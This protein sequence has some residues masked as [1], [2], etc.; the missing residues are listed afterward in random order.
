[1][2]HPKL[3]SV[4]RKVKAMLLSG[5]SRHAIASKLN[6][7]KSSVYDVVAN[8]EHYGEIRAIPG[9]KNPVIY[10][11]PNISGNPTNLPPKGEESGDSG[12]NGWAVRNNGTSGSWSEGLPEVNFTGI[13]IGPDCP[14]GYVVAHMSGGIR[15]TKV[16]KV[17]TFDPIKDVHGHTVGIWDPEKPTNMKGNRVRSATVHIFGVD[18]KVQIRFGSKGGMVFM[19]YPGR[20]FLD[21]LKFDSKDEAKAVFVDRALYIAG[22]LRQNGWQLTDPEIKGLFDC[23]L[24]S[25]PIV[26]HIPQGEDVHD[27]DIFVDTSPGIP[28][29]EMSEAHGG[30][31][32][33]EKVQIFANLPT[34]IKSAR[35]R[36]SSVESS[37]SEAHSKIETASKVIVSHQT[38]LDDMD[39]ILS[40][41][42]GIQEKQTTALVNIG[43]HT[44]LII[45]AQNNINAAIAAGTQRQLDSF[46]TVRTAGDPPADNPNDSDKPTRLE[47]YI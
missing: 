8:L 30:M 44:N 34:E 37:A 23:A 45:A 10:E 21:P 4:E 43:E 33:W 9:T 22:L 5:H 31:T 46:D 35:A 13:S 11:D 6:M 18:T 28:E 16:R 29:A 27:G 38:R 3:T 42:I 19:V 41:M 2:T 36:L 14:E 7:P 26:A 32:D 20:L 25:S 47:G 40:R 1:M 12:S 39:S 17:G 24:P 15:F